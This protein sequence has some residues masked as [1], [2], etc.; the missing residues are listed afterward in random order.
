MLILTRLSGERIWIGD[1][2]ILTVIDIRGDRVRLGFTCDRSVVI[3][4]EEIRKAKERD[5]ENEK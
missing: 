4:R 5:K 1:D 3:D 2:V